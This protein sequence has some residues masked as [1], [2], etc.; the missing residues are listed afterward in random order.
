MREN[1]KAAKCIANVLERRSKI[2]GKQTMF[3]ILS[4][5]GYLNSIED[6]PFQRG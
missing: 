6:G 4:L 1:R 3:Q 2:K 5:F